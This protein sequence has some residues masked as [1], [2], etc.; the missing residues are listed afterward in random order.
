MSDT[1]K[2][3]AEMAEAA[4]RKLDRRMDTLETFDAVV[5]EIVTASLN[6][7]DA[8]P[9]EP[10]TRDDERDL[11]LVDEPG[12]TNREVW[13]QVKEAAADELMVEALACEGNLSVEKAQAAI[14]AMPYPGDAQ[15]AL[16]A[17]DKRVRG[18][19]LEETLPVA[20]ALAAAI[21]LLEKGGKKA[22]PSDKMF[23][24]MLA[25]YQKT[26]D[27]YRATLARIEAE[28]EIGGE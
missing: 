3:R 16:D 18:E 26:L 23:E 27:E 12:Q 19:A 5:H 4:L 28:P 8:D 10:I 17:R 2:A 14:R 25:D 1:Y 15:A 24:Q 6:Q 13:E 22:A 9:A 11:T 20:G 7:T 21:S